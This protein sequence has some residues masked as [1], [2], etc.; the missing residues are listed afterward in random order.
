MAE[1]SVSTPPAT[2]PNRVRLAVTVAGWSWLTVAVT[3]FAVIAV[4]GITAAVSY[5]HEYHLSYSNGQPAWVSG[6]NPFT[7]DGLILGASV[8]LFWAASRG[9]RGFGQLWRPGGVLVVGILATVA[10]N[11]AAGLDETWLRPVV[12]AWP[13]VAL[14]LISDVFFWLMGKIRALANGEELQPETG[15]DCPAP[16]APPVSLAEALPLARAELRRQNKPSGEQALADAFAVTRHQV[17][18]ILAQADA[19]EPAAEPD[20]SPNGHQADALLN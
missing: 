18:T 13:G 7:V 15:C 4:T 19:P 17:R 11:L 16:P 12:S 5:D 9:I 8:V 14:I 20:A 6:C 2:L 3:L 1:P 10:A